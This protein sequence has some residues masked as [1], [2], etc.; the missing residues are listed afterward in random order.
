[1]AISDAYFLAVQNINAAIG[2]TPL[3]PGLN[4]ARVGDWTLAVN[5]S[6]EPTHWQGEPLGPWEVG[7]D[8][9][10]SM[11]LAVLGPAGGAF[12]AGTE[13]RFIADMMAAAAGAS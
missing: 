10:L 3:P 6:N 2:I 1:M 12:L 11:A 13:D 4:V 5:A 8:H 7:A 9:E